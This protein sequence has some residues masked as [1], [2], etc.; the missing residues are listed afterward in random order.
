MVTT[1]LTVHLPKRKVALGEILL[2]FDK[3]TAFLSSSRATS[4]WKRVTCRRTRCFTLIKAINLRIIIYKKVYIIYNNNKK[5]YYADYLIVGQINQCLN[6][7][8]NIET[9][10]FKDNKVKMY[11]PC[12]DTV[13]GQFHGLYETLV[14]LMVRSN[15]DKC[16]LD[17]GFSKQNSKML[18][19]S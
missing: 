19:F 18:L 6:P 11:R 8:E 3:T 2:M 5:V 10:R 7:P 4:P 12:Y 14:Y 17:Y 9:Y 16:F 1:E 13:T 15:S